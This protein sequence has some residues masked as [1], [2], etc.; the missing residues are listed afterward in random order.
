MEEITIGTEEWLSQ[1][2]E[3]IVDPGRKI[4]DPHHHLWNAGF[5]KYFVEEL[6]EDIETSGHNVKATV[7][8]MSSS[9]T[10]M[11][12]KDGPDEFKP[13][14]EI[15]FAT[16]EV[17]HTKLGYCLTTFEMSL[18]QLLNLSE[19]DILTAGKAQDAI[20]VGLFNL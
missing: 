20:A 7:Y 9:N 18:D 8:I 2:Q 15:K 16:Q 12:S 14:T 17:R 5:G 6:L 19:D 10:V 11:Y 4:I 3:E 1:V 13:L